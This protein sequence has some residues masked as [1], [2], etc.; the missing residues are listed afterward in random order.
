MRRCDKCG[1]DVAGD[2]DLCPLCQARLSGEPSRAPFPRN[3]VR[4]SGAMALRV[5]AFV[6]GLGVLA[7]IF[8]GLMLH[9]PGGIV[10][11]GC[12]ALLVNYAFVR[13]MLMH[14]PDFLRL[15]VRYFLILLLLAFVWFALTGNLVV[16]TYVIPSI[17]LLALVFDAVLVCVFRGT[18]VSG[19]AKYLLFDVVLGICPLALVA[20]GLTTWDILAYVSA[21]VAC[22]L[23]LALV[24]F[25][26]ERLVAELR[27]LF[28]A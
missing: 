18:F 21:L 5:L 16:T 14:T 10:A 2:L 15:V 26:H 4:R 1:I 8:L 3:Q 28:A 27:K 17:C 12:V 7:L 24:V 22:V 20:T 23:L 25:M 6:T 19:Y 13:H 11:T 9:L